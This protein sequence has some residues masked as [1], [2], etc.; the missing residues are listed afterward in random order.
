MGIILLSTETQGSPRPG[1][2]KH[3]TSLLA[4]KVGV[5]TNPTIMV[6]PL[7]AWPL[8]PHPDSVTCCSPQVP[9]SLLLLDFTHVRLACLPPLPSTLSSPTL[10]KTCVP[11]ADPLESHP[12]SLPLLLC[13]W[14]GYA[15]PMSPP[16][17]V[18]VSACLHL[19]FLTVGS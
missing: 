12:A 14:L 18:K 3:V 13:V 8:L 15:A 1:T 17:V 9:G 16:C 11:V 7:P 6:D 10:G 2:R 4:S 19:P 5:L